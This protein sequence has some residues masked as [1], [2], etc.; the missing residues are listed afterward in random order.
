VVFL[1]N[2]EY[3]I[4]HK[5][6]ITVCFLYQTMQ[7]VKDNDKENTTEENLDQEVSEVERR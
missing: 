2:Q 6:S 3:D 7:N 1:S 5:G 4:S